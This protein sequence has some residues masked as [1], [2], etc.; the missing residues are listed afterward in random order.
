MLAFSHQSLLALGLTDPPASTPA[1][2][3]STVVSGHRFVVPAGVKP[4]PARRARTVA[5]PAANSASNSTEAVT[6]STTS[7]TRVESL[8][9][10]LARDEEEQLGLEQ[11]LEALLEDIS[12]AADPFAALLFL[13]RLCDALGDRATFFHEMREDAAFRARLLK[14]GAWS[15]SLA[16]AVVRE[17]ALLELVRSGARPIS[18][19]DLRKRVH[20]EVEACAS[21]AEKLDTLRAL[22][23]REFLRIGLLD[24]ERDT[25]R[26]ADNF[27]LV[28]RQISDLAMVCVAQALQVLAPGGVPFCVL[29]MGKGGARELNYS[30]DIDLI[31]LHEGESA[32]MDTLGVE[33]L[34][35]LN[36]Q[37][38]SGFLYRVDM[39]LRPDGASG[40]LVTPL[41]YAL[42]Y[43][44]SFAAP[45][46]WQAL[47]KA[48]AIAGD[49]RLGRR[50]RRFARGVTWA[51]RPTTTTCAPSSP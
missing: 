2:K 7:T 6:V 51:R 35:E 22:R 18:R 30:S 47:I 25:W 1:S 13:S 26:D 29:I 5:A 16:D 44:E 48:R 33:L 49:A 9:A 50:F 40:P 41:G 3:Q 15:Q 32:E 19:P 21:K 8:L 36:A 10:G 39:R 14:L 42:S 11:V 46:E 34:R 23:R 12:R 17:P 28:T 4:R 43:Y 20:A 45:W 37:T 27:G 24:I 38:P 31:F